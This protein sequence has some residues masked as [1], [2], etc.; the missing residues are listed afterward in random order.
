LQEASGPGAANTST[1][2]PGS[3]EIGRAARGGQAKG[4]LAQAFFYCPFSIARF[5]S[6]TLALAHRGRSQPRS[7]LHSL[8]CCQLRSTKPQPV[9]CTYLIII[10]SL[11]LFHRI[12]Y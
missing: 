11:I 10:Q 4:L 6:S 8:F 1:A 12:I 3:Q 5:Q 7:I 2:I 9:Y